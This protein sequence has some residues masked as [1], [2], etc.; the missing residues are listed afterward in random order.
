MREPP[1]TPPPES[2]GWEPRRGGWRRRHRASTVL[3]RLA[4]AGAGCAGLVFVFLTKV[5]PHFTKVIL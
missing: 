5:A 4:M 3:F 2:F 1:Y